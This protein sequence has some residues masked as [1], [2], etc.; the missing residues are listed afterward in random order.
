MMGFARGNTVGVREKMSDINK[1]YSQAKHAI[2]TAVQNGDWTAQQARER[3]QK[4]N[5]YYKEVKRI[6]KS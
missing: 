2:D 3:R 4:L 5:D 6:A 1:I